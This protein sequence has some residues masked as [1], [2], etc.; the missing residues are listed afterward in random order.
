[1][2]NQGVSVRPNGK[3]QIHHHKFIVIDNVAVET[4][5]FNYSASAAD[6][7]AENVIMLRGVPEIAAEYVKQWKKLW[8]EGEA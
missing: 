7:N 6:K 2:A 4:G 8:D 1:L 5:S 3:Y